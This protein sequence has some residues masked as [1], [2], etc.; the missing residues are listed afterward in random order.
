MKLNEAFLSLRRAL[1]S[2]T[3]GATEGRYASLKAVRTAYAEV[4]E[5]LGDETEHTLRNLLA[6]GEVV[7]NGV[8]FST[9]L[10]GARLALFRAIV[11]NDDLEKLTK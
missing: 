4:K 5:Y 8:T 1:V 7:I 11:A 2:A 3:S 6:E 10:S 9:P